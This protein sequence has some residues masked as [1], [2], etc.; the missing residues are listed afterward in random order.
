MD[1]KNLSTLK[2]HKLTQAQYDRELAAGNIDENAL[3]LTPEEEIDLTPYA[4]K[5]QVSDTYETKTDANAKL[6]ESKLYTEEEFAILLASVA[7][8]E[9]R[10]AA[11]ESSIA[12]VT[13]VED[14]LGI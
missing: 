8:L 12:S 4:T 5:E 10:I 9:A 2:I 13:E 11:L 14:S 6:D 7:T 1:T 3:Y